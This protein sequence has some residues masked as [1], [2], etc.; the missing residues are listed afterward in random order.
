MSING[1]R[2]A[3]TNENINNAPN[4]AGV[5]ELYDGSMLTYIGRA[6]G[7]SVT[8]RTRLK[9]HKS[10]REGMCTKNATIYKR[11]V[12]SSP[13]ARERELLRE[14]YHRHGKLPRCND[15]MP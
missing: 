2:Y 15:V 3:F 12:T 13:V 7:G 14:Y 8:I 11:E 6:Q 10:G 5:Y 4:S 1:K 9:D